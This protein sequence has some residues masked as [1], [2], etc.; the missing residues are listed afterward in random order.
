IGGSPKAIGCTFS[1]NKTDG[2]TVVDRFVE[3]GGAIYNYYDSNMSFKN[4]S[5]NNNETLAGGGNDM[6]SYAARPRLVN[7]DFKAQVVEWNFY[8]CDLE[9][10]DLHPSFV[11]NGLYDL[12]LSLESVKRFIFVG[13]KPINLSIT[14]PMVPDRPFVVSEGVEVFG[15]DIFV[16][17][18]SELI[19]E[20][21]AILNLGGAG[22]LIC[23]GLLRARGQAIIRN[24]TIDITR[25]SFEGDVN[26]S[27]NLITA[28][29]GASFGQFFIED[30]VRVVDNEIHADGDR[31][32]DLDPSVFNGIM[33]NNLIY[34]LITEGVGSVRGGLLELRGQKDLVDSYTYDPNNIF[35][36]QVDPGAIPDCNTINWSLQELKLIDDAKVNLT[37]RF[38]F[39]EPFDAGGAEEVLYV[40]D[41]I[42]GN[43]VVLNTSFNRIFYE[44]LIA[45]PNAIIK[46]DPLLGFSLSNIACDDDIEFITR[47][48]HNNYTDSDPAEPDETRIHIERIVGDPIDP[49]GMMKMENFEIFYPEPQPGK[50]VLYHAKAKGLFARTSEAEDRILIWFEYL[51]CSD[52]PSTELIIYLSDVAELQDPRDPG[53]YLEVGR[54]AAPPVGRAGAFRSGRFGVF[55]EY[56]S[57][58]DLNFIR[59][60][61][62]EL[63]LVGPDGSCVLINNWDPMIVCDPM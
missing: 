58:G 8:N 41:L 59:G 24:T 43:N 15:G 20:G 35:L 1:G 56:V 42:L 55:Q 62:M 31:Y 19:F 4:C 30:T 61:R 51:F 54:L 26:I 23:D 22:E 49:S 12:G 21:N 14:G 33:K 9:L 28:E 5:F 18:E 48:L 38:D 40:R 32:M 39:H 17:L 11:F 7:W 44:N 52:D 46:N 27:N 6:F 29:A 25:T 36:C 37:N 53:H 50:T 60:L 34:V 2:E 63:E 13:A 57:K 16:P 47:I 45:E 3:G 10:A